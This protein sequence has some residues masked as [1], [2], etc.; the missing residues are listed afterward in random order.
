MAT[1]ERYDRR[2]F[3]GQ[4]L[5]TTAGGVL[6]VG[7]GDLL[8]ACSSSSGGT[9]GSTTPKK[10][11]SAIFATEAE[12]NSFDPR[13]GAWDSTGLL[14]AHTVFDPLLAQ[15]ADGTVKP[16]LAQS[17]TPNADYTQWTIKLR[18]NIKFHDGTPLDATAVKA[19]LD[20]TSK[21]PLTGPALFNL[22]STTVVD[23]MTVT[24]TTKTPWVPFPYYLTQQLGMMA[25]LKQLADTSGKANPIGTGPFVFKEWLPGDHFTATRNPNYWR[26]GL[27][28][29]DS[30]TYKPIPD[31]TSRENSLKAGNI[32][33]M[34]TSETQNVAD[35][36]HDSSVLQ[37]NDMNSVL[38]EPDQ[39]FIM[40]NTA[41]PP[42]DDLRVRQALAYATDQQRVIS[43]VYNS[44]TP[45]SSGPFTQGSPYYS[46]T[47]Y[48]TFDLNKAKALVADYQTSKGPISFKFGTTNSPK[49]LQRN[50]LL[51]A[52]WKD[53][54]IQTEIIQVEQS[55]Y[56]LNAIVG[57]YQAYGW[58]QFN[59]PDPDANFVWWSSATALPPGKQALNFAR[60]K[61]PQIDQAL[62]IGRVSADQS[63]RA[64]AYQK[65]AERF[66]ADVPY[67]WLTR[68]VWMVAARASV[69]G[70][71][72]DVDLPDGG[73]A[74][75][76]G[77][78]I[79]S[80]A[81]IW[82]K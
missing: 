23:P 80:P 9:S 65:V 64:A 38:G 48:P 70:G 56:I 28:Y 68:T 54:G 50:Q 42:T 61:D 39:N 4:V 79:I 78:G 12:I 1:L 55:P 36:I 19:N 24:V 6:L 11:G 58:R 67:I 37:V 46:Q 82:R 13:S 77:S 26:S 51:Q 66:A 17:V 22:A 69:I 45:P 81:N 25:G 27:P 47:S 15:A 7:A 73:K 29:L 20:G 18:P 10:G 30:I 76:M 8:A 44:L 41:V 32:D 3:L 35:L 33:L 57:N 21:S 59:S 74:R 49:N 40:L 53:A 31:P 43:T 5:Y 14:Y 71:F 62:G 16:Y 75:G 52:M 34:H 63:A 2:K 72:N 60:N